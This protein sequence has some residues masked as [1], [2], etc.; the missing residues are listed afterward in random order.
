[1][2]LALR[3][4]GL[5][6]DPSRDSLLEAAGR[7]A[8]YV[9][10]RPRFARS[11]PAAG[12]TTDLDGEIR[13]DTQEGAI[14][15]GSNSNHETS[16]RSAHVRRAQIHFGVRRILSPSTEDELPESIRRQTTPRRGHDLARACPADDEL[17]SLQNLLRGPPGLFDRD[18]RQEDPV[19]LAV[20]LD[21]TRAG[22]QSQK[23]QRSELML[24]NHFPKG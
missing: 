1:M 21:G 5:C 16:G 10:D 7:F 24:M 14:I 9:H 2:M 8:R 6:A 12:L 4:L 23:E 18:P 20:R 13:G 3:A 17:G 11:E 15:E 19:S 22:R